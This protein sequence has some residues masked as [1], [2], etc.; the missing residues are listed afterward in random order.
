MLVLCV[1]GWVWRPALEMNGWDGTLEVD[2]VSYQQSG[3][4][5]QDIEPENFRDAS[6]NKLRRYRLGSGCTVERRSPSTSSPRQ[7]KIRRKIALL[8]KATAD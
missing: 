4:D 8:N 6:L 1:R 5:G 3:H 7:G 2:L